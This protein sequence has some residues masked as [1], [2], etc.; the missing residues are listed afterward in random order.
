LGFTAAVFAEDEEQP[1][2]EWGRRNPVLDQLTCAL[3]G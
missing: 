3:E 2:L 1:V